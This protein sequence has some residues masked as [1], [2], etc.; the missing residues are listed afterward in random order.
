[1]TVSASVESKI[2]DIRMSFKDGVN[3]SAED[4]LSFS[5]NDPD[6]IDAFLQALPEVFIHH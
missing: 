4:A 1:M 6:F 2:K 3:G 5:V